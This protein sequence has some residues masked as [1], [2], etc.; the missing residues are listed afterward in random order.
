MANGFVAIILHGVGPKT[1]VYE[2][3]MG[4]YIRLFTIGGIYFRQLEHNPFDH[5]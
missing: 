2:F 1:S 4:K 3:C 5:L